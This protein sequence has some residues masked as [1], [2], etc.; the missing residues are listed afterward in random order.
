MYWTRTVVAAHAAGMAT[1]AVQYTYGANTDAARDR[2]RPE[3]K[4]FLAGLHE[5]GRLRVSGPVDGGALLIFEGSSAE[6]VAA[7]LD[8]DPFRRE[9]LIAERTVREWTIFFGGLK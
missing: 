6:E 5:A 7:L 1:F 8:G 9:G 3:H 2:F 4:D